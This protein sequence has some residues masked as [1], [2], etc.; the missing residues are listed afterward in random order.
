[1][2]DT[3][4]CYYSGYNLYVTDVWCL[5]CYVQFVWCVVFVPSMNDSHMYHIAVNMPLM[6]HVQCSTGC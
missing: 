5:V 6:L 1:M 3:L 4:S 2:L